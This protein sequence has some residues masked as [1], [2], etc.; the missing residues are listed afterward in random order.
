[1]KI[2]VLLALTA[3]WLSI[4]TVEMY[5]ADSDLTEARKHS[6]S[7]RGIQVPHGDE[8]FV[9]LS[10]DLDVK[11][12]TLL[13]VY[14][15]DKGVQTYL[16]VTQAQVAKCPKWDGNGV[17]PM[18]LNEALAM[19]RTYLAR[20]Y[21]NQSKFPLTSGSVALIYSEKIPNRWYYSLDFMVKIPIKDGWT[22]RQFLVNLLMDGTI[23]KLQPIREQK[24]ANKA[25]DRTR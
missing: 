4:H 20:E 24:A 15:T 19:A 17:P 3:V 6:D 22:S 2:P 16:A 25:S 14:S 23:L 5:A 12:A 8:A 18:T 7:L 9:K 1:M 10:R 21:P 11:G 13:K